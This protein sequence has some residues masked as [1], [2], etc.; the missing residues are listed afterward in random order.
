VIQKSG[1]GGV[2][3]I[4]NALEKLKQESPKGAT[5]G[6]KK[7]GTHLQKESQKVVPV[8]TG[9]LRASAYTKIRWANTK[10]VDVV[11]GYTM[12]YAIYVHEDLFARHK[13]GKIAKYLEK[14]ARQLAKKL[15]KMVADEVKK[16]VKKAANRKRGK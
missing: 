11:V 6:L 12:P 9:A 7:A 13:P 8:D 14:P 1:V 3:L 15:L 5:K 16:V 4:L 10:R 2:K